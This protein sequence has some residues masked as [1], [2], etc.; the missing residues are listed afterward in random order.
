MP[1]LLT[2]QQAI[3]TTQAWVKSFIIGYSIC[4]FAK[5][6]W[7][8]GSIYYTV[9]RTAD[10]EYFLEQLI[11]EC[12]RLDSD[13][14]IETTLLIYPEAL[15]SFDDYLDYLD[16]AE[17]LLIEQGYEGI[18]QLASFHPGYC[19]EGAAQDDPANYT[20]RSPYPML[21]LIREESIE[22]AVAAYPHPENIP[23][24]NIELTRR[25]G[26]AKMQALLAACYQ[27]GQ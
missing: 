22:R 24:R 1:K 7:D 23:E 14:G 10:I 16:I 15:S 27:A 4:P 3:S 17:R 21:H 20:N 11:Q 18:Y 26:L 25:L 5:R 9:K 2:D 8:R 12:E 19:F 13:D 6:E